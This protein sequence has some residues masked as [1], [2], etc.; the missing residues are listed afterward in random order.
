MGSSQAFQRFR[1][2]YSGNP[3]IRGAPDLPGL[4]STKR[5]SSR[6]GSPGRRGRREEA[7]VS[8]PAR[9]HR[10]V[11]HAEPGARRAVRSVRVRRGLAAV[12]AL[13]RRVPRALPPPGGRPARASATPGRGVAHPRPRDRRPRPPRPARR[14][15]ARP[16]VRAEPS[17]A[18]G[19]AAGTPPRA[20]PARRPG[21]PRLV[22]P[23]GPGDPRGWEVGAGHL[24]GRL[25]CQL[26]GFTASPALLYA[27]NL[28][29]LCKS[30]SF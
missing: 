9:G 10:D 26:W 15:S 23:V 12:R 8:L 21:P 27:P 5:G 20:P 24:N 30:T 13:R 7:S 16:P 18:A 3:L 11:R 2:R 1:A 19:P 22:P 6:G 25:G 4:G 14:A 17:R 28:M 29:V